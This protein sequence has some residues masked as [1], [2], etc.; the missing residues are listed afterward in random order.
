MCMLRVKIAT[1][2]SPENNFWNFWAT[3]KSGVHNW[4]LLHQMASAQNAP[5]R[6]EPRCGKEAAQR[7]QTIQG[8]RFAG[9]PAETKFKRQNFRANILEPQGW[10]FWQ[11]W[12][13][14]SCNHP[15][16][17]PSY[18]LIWALGSD[19]SQTVSLRSISIATWWDEQQ[20]LSFEKWSQSGNN[21]NP[22]LL[23]RHLQP[24][25]AGGR[26]AFHWHN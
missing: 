13:L 23:W 16:H 5:V 10:R 4:R 24:S 18:R 26:A 14:F 25:G 20:K 1:G 11:C 6:E 17:L 22:S 9:A 3:L 19:W 7:W 21:S 15:P 2:F 8:W 12:S